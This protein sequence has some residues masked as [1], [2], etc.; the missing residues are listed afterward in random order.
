MSIVNMAMTS[1]LVMYGLT[2]T[3]TV[4]DEWGMT[5]VLDIGLFNT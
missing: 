5:Y 3:I 1:N 4:T 2:V